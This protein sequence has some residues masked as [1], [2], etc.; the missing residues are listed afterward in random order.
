MAQKSLLND[1]P[2]TLVEKYRQLLIK[3]GIPIE[4]M[5]LFGSWAK[6]K[7]KLYSDLDICVVSKKFG[8]DPFSEMVMLKKIASKIEPLIEPHPYNPADL[9]DPWDPLAAEIR[10]SGMVV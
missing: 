7:A 10:K 6:G 2:E 1:K 5:I 8:R 4:K 3:H 9:A